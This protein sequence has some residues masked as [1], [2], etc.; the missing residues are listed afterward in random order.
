MPDPFGPLLKRWRQTRR[1][2]QEALAL[3]AEISTRHLSC[4]ETGKAKPSREMVLL[5]SSA[6]ELDL[7]ERNMMLGCA[8]F[9]P[10][11]TSSGLESL[12]MAPIR[13]A[14]DLMLTQQEPYGAVVVDRL[15]NVLQMNDGAL[16]MMGRFM[17][18]P[19]D[20]PK[21]AGNVVR[22]TLHPAGLRPSIVNWVEVAVFTL[23]RIDHECAMYPHDDERLALREE[24]RRYPGIAAIELP[25]SAGLGA[26]VAQVHLRRGDDEARLF[27]MVT[28]LGTPL[29][30]TAQDLAIESYFPADEATEAWLRRLSA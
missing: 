13:R 1:L 22:A 5:L 7:R 11:Y 30:I 19:P 23:E 16:R 8:G 9:A 21:I 17:P 28:T 18:E 20:D 2:S 3:D 6:L 29:D 25:V 27:T 14:I 24:V 12:A 4:L 15:W 26:P 10:V